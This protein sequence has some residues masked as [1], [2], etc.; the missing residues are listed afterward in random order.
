[1]V[2]KNKYKYTSTLLELHFLVQCTVHCTVHSSD[3]KKEK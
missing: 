3:L 2:K 1:M